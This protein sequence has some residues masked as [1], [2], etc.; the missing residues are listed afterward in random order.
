[1]RLGFFIY[2]LFFLKHSDIQGACFWTSSSSANLK[3]FYFRPWEEENSSFW[4][5][6]PG[7]DARGVTRGER[8]I[9]NRADV[10]Q[11]DDPEPVWCVWTDR[12]LAGP[13]VHRET[14]TQE[15][16]GT[17]ATASVF[18]CMYTYVCVRSI[19]GGYLEVLHACHYHVLYSC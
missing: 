8:D 3:E 10:H 18:S 6:E 9:K 17:P 5:K 1:M 4:L 11:Q 7:G 12:W 19:K 15:S 13:D 14:Y 2:F 16:E